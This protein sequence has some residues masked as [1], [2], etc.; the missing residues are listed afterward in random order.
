M[1]DLP[2]ILVGP[3]LRRT[4]ADRVTVWLALKESSQVELKI[5]ATESGKG[6]NLQ[7]L[8]A[9][10][11]T[12]TVQIGKYLHLATV[13]AR[14]TSDSY[15]ERGRVYAYNLWFADRQQDLVAAANTESFTSN[16]SYFTHQLPTFTLPAKDPGQLQIVHGSCRKPHG[17]GKDAL[18]LVDNLIERG[19]SSA[20][21]RPQQLFLTGDQIY[22]DDVADPILWLAQG[23]GSLLLGWEEKLPLLEGS[24]AASQLPPGKRSEIARI[25]GGFTGMLDKQPEKAKSHLFSLGEFFATYLLSWSPVLAPDYFPKGNSLFDGERAKTWDSEV[26]KIQ[27]FFSTLSQVRRALANIATY[28]ICDDHDV[29]DDWYLNREWCDR[30]LSKPLG[31]RVLLNG[32]LS[33]ALCQA[34]G[35][36]PEQFVSESAGEKLLQAAVRHS[37]A[38]GIDLATITE[39]DRYLGIPP[40]NADTGLPQ[41]ERDGK[42]W[43]LQRDREALSWHYRLRHS[44]HEIIV[45]DTR[46]W[47]GYPQEPKGIAPPMLLCPTAFKEQL[48]LPLEFSDNL[49]QTGKTDIKLTI[50]VLP[51]NMVTLSII[52]KIQRLDLNRNKVFDND[53]GD[54]WNFNETAFA[55]LIVSLC[56]RRDRVVILSGDIH[57]SCAVRLSQ[58]Y[59]SARKA[60]VLVQLTSSAFK[61]SELKTQLIHTKLKY[62]LP[63]PPENWL[64]WQ[65]PLNFARIPAPWWRRLGFG[66]V[67]SLPSAFPDWQYRVEWSKRRAS[68]QAWQL[69]TSGKKQSN[70]WQR[71]LD[72]IAY[73]LWRNPWFQHGAEVV[74]HNN[75]SLVR[76]QVSP[77]N[78]PLLVI[79]ETYWHPPDNTPAT[80]KCEYVVDLNSDSPPPLKASDRN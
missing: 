5:Y 79:Q 29:S 7:Q 54:S 40:Q 25:E 67:R 70:L 1:E 6:E 78:E 9:E 36:S 19:A 35:N 48:E 80:V 32:L 8:V 63:E 20:N 71:F 64:V 15:L 2:L 14:S 74:G 43:I 13:T 61:N 39:L 59:G 46:T 38:A 58:W 72:F 50:I 17:G 12:N 47:R 69:K 31:R 66:R 57:Y 65:K 41:L 44:Q 27:S 42:V 51:T 16:L 23:I 53:V 45:L 52:D 4:Q 34:W 49:N 28:T 30:V 10:G 3:I 77:T 24:I 33:Y 75:I 73:L 22:A 37:A 55:K 11:K 68:K 62:L 60:S 76:F 21:E 18:A 26:T 56:Q